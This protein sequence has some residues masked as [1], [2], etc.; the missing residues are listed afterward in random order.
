MA[1]AAK[2]TKENEFDERRETLVIE[3][4]TTFPPELD[5]P[6]SAKD[7]IVTA[8]HAAPAEAKVLTYVR[9]PT[10]FIRHVTVTSDDL[11]RLKF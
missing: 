7:E 9:C 3:M 6:H 1:K 5:Y 8:L 11:K 10:G 2:E 4:K